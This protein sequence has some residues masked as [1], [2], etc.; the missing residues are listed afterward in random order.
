[1]ENVRELDAGPPVR[2]YPG[3]LSSSGSG[4]RRSSASPELREKKASAEID[5]LIAF[6][7]ASD[8]Y[9]TTE[10]EEQV[11]DGSIDELEPALRAYCRRAQATASLGDELEADY[12]D[13]T[14]TDDELRSAAA[15][16]PASTA[17][18]PSGLQGG[19]LDLEDEHDGAE[20][21]EDEPWLGWTTSGSAVSTTMSGTIATGRTTSRC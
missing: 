20:P 14:T 16:P 4:K 21:G 11:D 1:M 18:D 15:L 9:V 10:L 2:F 13:G 5:R 7:D 6:L 3:W 8:P 19:S 17:D 12:A